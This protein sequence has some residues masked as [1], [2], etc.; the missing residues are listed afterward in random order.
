MLIVRHEKSP[1]AKTEFGKNKIGASE[2]Q[3]S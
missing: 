2:G 1:A 3:K